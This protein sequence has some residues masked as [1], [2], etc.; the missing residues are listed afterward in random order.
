MRRFLNGGAMVFCA[1]C[2]AVAAV[3]RVPRCLWRRCLIGQPLFIQ[4]VLPEG[5]TGRRQRSS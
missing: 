2:G 3:L 4:R 1:G 5:L